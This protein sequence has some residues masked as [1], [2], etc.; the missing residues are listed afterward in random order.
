MIL[1]FEDALLSKTVNSSFFGASETNN[2]IKQWGR[3]EMTGLRESAG[4]GLAVGF[5]GCHGRL[6]AGQV[7]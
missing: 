1:T 2:S 4:G 5:K 6:Q 3:S 7:S